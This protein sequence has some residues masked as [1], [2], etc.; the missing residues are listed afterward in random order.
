[1]DSQTKIEAAT[2]T[3]W[4]EWAGMLDAIDAD[5]LPYGE[6]VELLARTLDVPENERLALARSIV[7]AYRK[8]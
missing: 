5:C 8:K 7:R 6:Q 4:G 1:M 2:G 3:S